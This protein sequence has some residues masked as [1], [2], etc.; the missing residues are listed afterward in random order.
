M[1]CDEGSSEQLPQQGKCEEWPGQVRVSITL[2]S[3]HS[4]WSPAALMSSTEGLCSRAHQSYSGWGEG[5][6]FTWFVMILEYVN[7]LLYYLSLDNQL[8]SNFNIA[9]M[10]LSDF[11]DYQTFLAG[12]NTSVRMSQLEHRLR[13]RCRHARQT[14]HKLPQIS[15][16]ILEF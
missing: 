13:I 2:M 1:Y 11:G 16:R 5:E 7:L 8:F 9:L 14:K 6:L 4:L 15:P 12:S 10:V 3:D